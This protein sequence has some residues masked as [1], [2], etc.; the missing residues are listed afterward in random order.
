MRRSFIAPIKSMNLGD[1]LVG[2][3]VDLHRWCRRQWSA[4][5]VGAA[6][7]AIHRCQCVFG[8]PCRFGFSESIL[9]ELRIYKSKN[10]LEV[11]CPF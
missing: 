6:P 9:F 7:E 2:I 1:L 4:H 11:F 5:L 8:E 3:R 10:T